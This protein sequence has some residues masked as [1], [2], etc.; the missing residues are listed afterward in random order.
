MTWRMRWLALLVLV[1]TPMTASAWLRQRPMV[2]AAY[3]YFPAPVLAVPTAVPVYVAPP[4]VCV[5]PP[6]PGNLAVPIPAPPAATPPP[7][8]GP[9]P[10]PPTNAPKAGVSESGASTSY[11]AG[12]ASPA[13]AA[14]C[15]VAFWNYSDRNIILT[16]D[17]Q[18][19]QL[20]RNKGI[21]LDLPRAFTWQTDGR[22][23]EQEQVPA[24]S[25]GMEIVIRR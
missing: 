22:G 10:A 12:S 14:V 15:T 21:T 8:P 16:V 17:G 25:S 5:P 24:G 13:A 2:T 11:Y 1:M 3:Y 20:P 9:S 6:V 7:A 23:A 19:W 4:A 18:R